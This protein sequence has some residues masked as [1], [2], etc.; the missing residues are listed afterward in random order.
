M[1]DHDQRAV[2]LEK[3]REDCAAEINELDARIAEAVV[4]DRLADGQDDAALAKLRKR[5]A[6]IAVERADLAKAVA[7]A[8]SRAQDEKERATAKAMAAA[9]TEATKAADNLLKAAGAVDE[10][11]ANVEEAFAKL[12]LAT[13]DVSRAL[14]AAG[15]TDTS[16]IHNTLGPSTRWAV[17]AAAPTLAEKADIPHA[18]TLRRRSLRESLRHV[19]PSFPAR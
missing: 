8:K 4:D 5:R 17:W 12:D 16:R 18:N 13:I 9:R 10:A 19:I 14:R 11:L 1:T 15:C 7:L 3:R 6:D 2:T